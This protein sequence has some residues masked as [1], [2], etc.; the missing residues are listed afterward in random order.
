MMILLLPVL[1][2]FLVGA[3]VVF[4]PFPTRNA[5]NRW[6]GIGVAAV[7]L[8]I[9]GMMI[10]ISPSESLTLIRLTPEISI[11]F[12]MDGLSRVFLALIA[13][14]WPV[15]TLYAFEYM[16]GEEHQGR[17]F[18]CY[19]ACYGIT[20][21]VAMSANMM[22]MYLFVELLTLVTI[23]LVAH[24]GDR[25]SMRAARKYM[26]YS[27]SGAT[28]SLV[29][30]MLLISRTGSTEFAAG[31]LSSCDNTDGLMTVAWFLT[32]L[33]FGVKAAA[34]PLHAWLPAAGVAPTPVTALLHAVAVVK[35]GVF[36]V[37]RSTYCAF[38]TAMLAG[39]WG[40][41]AGLAIAALTILYGSVTAFR[42]QHIKRR[43]AYSTISNLSYILF[44][45]MLM[46]D[47]GLTASLSH[48]LFH[49]VIK[50]TLFFCA[51]AVIRR[52]GREYMTQMTGL[53]RK[54]PRTFAAFTIG[55]L[56]LTGMPLLPGFISKINLI[57]A[58]AYSDSGVLAMTGI[59]ALLLSA[60]MTAGYLIL[61]VIRAWAGN[62][63]TAPVFTERDH[64]PGWRMQAVLAVLCAAMLAL[65]V[66][67]VPVMNALNAMIAAG[68]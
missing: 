46:T 59:A 68:I 41:K 34:F 56:A 43:L 12:R 64:D 38:G 60:L 48:M 51:G 67:A 40:Q 18:A 50:I 11:A 17:F 9:A 10:R 65:G 42:E 19:T 63:G 20:A 26:V 36:A 44:G 55:A 33:G 16:D 58:A 23:P 3:G 61:P 29:G 49:G 32:F 30:M 54:M 27:F 31:S 14:L 22:T 15:A 8:V 45:A 62:G 53:G 5:R 7:S 28:L 6:T 1:M 13:F 52:T 39:T 66:C 4:L 47:E 25:R 21:G 24:E 57:R 35:G 2:P 37:I